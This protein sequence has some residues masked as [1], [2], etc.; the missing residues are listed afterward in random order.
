MDYSKGRVTRQA[1]VGLPAGTCEEEYGRRGF[2][3]RVSHLYRSRPPVDWVDIEGELRPRAYVL[4]DLAGLGSGD[5]L[6]GRIPFLRNQDVELLFALVTAEMPYYFRNADADEVLF[7]H[8]GHGRLETDFGPLAYRSGD[9]LVI[10][11]G[12]IYRLIPAVETALLVIASRGEVEIPDRG[13]LGKHALFDPMAITVPEPEAGWDLGR[14]PFLVKV[15]RQ[16]RLS[17]VTYP[18]NPIT[19]VGWRG[20]LTVW[21]L[22]VADIRPVSSER[23]HLP[24]T[25]H[26]TFLMQNAVI[27]SFLPRPL[28]TGD[29]T[30]LKVPFYHANIDFDEVIFYHAGEFF[31]RGGISPGM[32]TFHPQGIHHGP[33]PTAVEASRDKERT[34]EQAVM[35][36]T[37]HPLEPTPEALTAEVADYWRSWMGK[38][39]T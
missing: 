34:N 23:Y 24:P 38:E 21:Q 33:H 13:I 10:P 17:T 22:N 3:G 25:A 8:R 20:D 11:R 2:F 35:V 7:V 6:A 36:D 16:G 30:A 37:R 32:V 31:S 4:A 14:G 1:H 19:A 9:Y 26:I 27:C 18:F 12:T 29:P 15:Q 5:Y 28:E 39:T